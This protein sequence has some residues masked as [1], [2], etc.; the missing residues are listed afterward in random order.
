MCDSTT[1]AEN[2]IY[3]QKRTV[4][5]REA[6]LAAGATLAAVL[7]G[8]SATTPVAKGPASGS[9]GNSASG[10]AGN[11]APGRTTLQ[12]GEGKRVIVATPDGEAEGF[13]VAPEGG[14]RPGVLIWPDVAGLRDAYRSMATRL[15]NEGYA[16]LVVNPY[17]RSSPLPI[18]QEFSEWRTARGRA[19]IGPMRAVLSAAGITSD[20]AAFVAWLDQQPEVDS[21][22]KIAATGYCMGGPFTFRTAAAAPQRVGVIASF[23]GGGLATDEPNSP[24]LLLA[25]AQA[26]ALIC[27]AQ[28]DDARDPSAKKNLREA[29]NAAQISAEIEVY[30]AQHGWCALD[31]PVYDEQQAERAW[32]CMLAMFQQHL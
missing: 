1:E 16:V 25:N 4:S 29:A 12:A 24:H 10:S 7:G 23:H 19:T 8:C 31:S 3:L 18:V 14:P 32:A 15:A 11:S 27:I 9:A 2:E 6:G 28:N 17:Y 5:R 20:G 22:K 30:S 26:A 13:F 21:T